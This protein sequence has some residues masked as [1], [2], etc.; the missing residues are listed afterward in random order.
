[1]AGFGSG[2]PLWF[3]ILAEAEAAGGHRLGPVGGRIV[4][5]V[6]LGLLKADQDGLLH[7]NSP[8]HGSWQPSPPIAPAPGQFGIG[9]LAVFA[10][11]ATRP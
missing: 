8:S 10:G 2:T 6:F 11:V 1:V 4:A 7:D 5:D 3:Y 9:D